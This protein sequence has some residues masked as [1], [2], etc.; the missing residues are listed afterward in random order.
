ME[1]YAHHPSSTFWTAPTSRE[2]TGL[3]SRLALKT[4]QPG[5][6]AVND[7]EA[8][9]KYVEEPTSAIELA[10]TVSAPK[11]RIRG[12]QRPPLAASIL[13]EISLK[14]RLR[15]QWQIAR[16]AALAAQVNRIHKSVK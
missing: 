14:N 16:G 12:N 11:R 1:P 3:H 8:T 13:D 4:R 6:P 2:E 15:K 5:N 9:D 7:E 10:T